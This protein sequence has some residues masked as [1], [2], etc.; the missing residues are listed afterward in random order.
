MNVGSTLYFSIDLL[1]Y[2]SYNGIVVK[3]AGFYYGRGHSHY[4]DGPWL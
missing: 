2:I 3:D 4:G 1:P